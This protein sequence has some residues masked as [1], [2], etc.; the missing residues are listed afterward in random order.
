MSFQRSKTIRGLLLCLVVVGSV[1]VYSDYQAARQAEALAEY[2]EATVHESKAAIQQTL[3]EL[4]LVRLNG[5]IHTALSPDKQAAEFNQDQCFP[6]NVDTSLEIEQAKVEVV[7]LHH[8]RKLSKDSDCRAG[9]QI[10]ISLTNTQIEDVYI[11]F[12]LLDSGQGDFT[13]TIPEQ[14]SLQRELQQVFEQLVNEP[15]LANRQHLNEVLFNLFMSVKQ[16]NFDEK[17]G[18]QFLKILLSAVHHHLLAKN[19]FQ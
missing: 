4:G 7:D 17:S 3:K 6:V 5:V 11:S 14:Q 18:E 2:R 9:G 8:C 12:N 16:N 13:I 19:V 15:Q 1:S 10:V